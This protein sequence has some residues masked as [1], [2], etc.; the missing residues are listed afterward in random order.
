MNRGNVY[1]LI[2]ISKLGSNTFKQR[3]THIKNV[4]GTFPHI[5]TAIYKNVSCVLH[6]MCTHIFFKS[7]SVMKFKSKIV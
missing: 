4:P 1:L 6:T 3:C 5:L 2:F 7:K